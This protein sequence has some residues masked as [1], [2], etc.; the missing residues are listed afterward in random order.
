MDV[1]NRT[2]GLNGAGVIIGVR[3]GRKIGFWEVEV[4]SGIWS[5]IADVAIS[6]RPEQMTHKPEAR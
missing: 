3:C 4:S 5:P 6:A 2:I 1:L